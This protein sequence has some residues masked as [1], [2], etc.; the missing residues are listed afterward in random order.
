MVLCSLHRLAPRL[1][2]VF[3]YLHSTEEFLCRFDSRDA[4]LI[5]ARLNLPKTTQV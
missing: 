4:Y 1:P 5:A 3:M 2:A